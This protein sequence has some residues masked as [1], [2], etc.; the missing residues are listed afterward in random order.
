MVA[1]GNRFGVFGPASILIS[2]MF[3]VQIAVLYVLHHNQKT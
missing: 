1:A 2:N 3:Q